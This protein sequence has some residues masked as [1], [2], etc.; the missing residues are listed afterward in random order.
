[1]IIVLHDEFKIAHRDIKP[2]NILFCNNK[3]KIADLGVS[4]NIDTINTVTNNHSLRGTLNYISPEE[5]INYIF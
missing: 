3:W 4:K 1:M 5:K 2:N